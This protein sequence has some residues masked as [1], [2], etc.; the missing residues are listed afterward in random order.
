MEPRQQIF[1]DLG[2]GGCYYLC[3]VDLA[4][5]LSGERIDAVPVFI[6]AAAKGWIA[7]SGEQAGYIFE[8]AALIGLLYPG[9]WQ[10]RKEGPL[11]VCQP[12]EFEI[13]RWERPTPKAIYSHF[14]RGFGDGTKRVKYDPLGN[15]RTVAE[16]QLVS[17]RILK[18]I[19]QA[20]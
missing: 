1:I 2:A 7:L 8:P 10:V 12:G 11:Y 15:S 9:N 3:Q 14:V 4:E 16:G 17:K 18:L 13:Q 20:A 5:E 19:G 6:Q